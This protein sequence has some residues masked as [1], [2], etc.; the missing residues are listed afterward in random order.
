MNRN[1]I[2]RT[3]TRPNRVL[4]ILAAAW[5]I[6][7]LAIGDAVASGP[8]AGADQPASVTTATQP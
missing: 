4:V 8:R 7:S 1:H 5:M 3:A 6:L 2:A